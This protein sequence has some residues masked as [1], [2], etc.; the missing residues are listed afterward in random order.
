MGARAVTPLLAVGDFGTSARAHVEAFEA[1]TAARLVGE[2]VNVLVPSDDVARDT[3]R[4]LGLREE[5]VEER[6]QF[7]HTGVVV[8]PI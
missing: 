6:I 5:L 8:A 2:G 3:L 1:D 7:S 4:E